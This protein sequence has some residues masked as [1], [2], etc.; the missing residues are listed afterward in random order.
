MRILVT[1]D[2]IGGVWTYT[3]ELV[4]GLARRGVEVMLVSFGEIASR[5]Q[6]EW[7]EGLTGVEYR[8]T[9]FRLEWM[10]ESE[11]D[12]LESAVYLQDLIEEWR[13]DMLHLNQFCYGVLDSA[14]PKLVVAHS[15]VVS[16]WQNV[17][18]EEPPPSEWFRRY[19]QIVRDGLHGSGVVIA[20][21][22]WMLAEVQRNFGP[23]PRTRVIYNGRTPSQFTPHMKKEDLVVTVG[24]LWDAG[25]QSNLLLELEPST[26]VCI[27]GCGE[28]PDPALRH[29]GIQNKSASHIE[30]RE[31][32]TERQIQLLL[33]RAAIYVATSKYEPF[34]L[35]ALEAA[36]SRCALVM[37][38]IPSHREIWGDAALYFRAN[39][40]GSLRRLIRDLSEDRV[41]RTSYANLACLRAR[42]MYSAENM[43]GQYLALYARLLSGRVM[44][45]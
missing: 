32:Q 26:R 21:S 25:K 44:A 17:K 20:P 18:G 34:G 2:T 35:A 41:L 6:T 38:D 36:L 12:L 43:V 3:R 40:A 9:A 22:R 10:Q 24:R 5:D 13:P 42:E 15:D 4:A 14:L 11:D 31:R 19:R 37:N 7:L 1:T 16:W 27:A 8:P 23:L 39:D 33:G 28:H 30:L 29:S 45:A